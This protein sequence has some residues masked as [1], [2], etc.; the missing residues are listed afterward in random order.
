MVKVRSGT[1]YL[2]SNAAAKYVLILGMVKVRLGT[3]HLKSLTKDFHLTLTNYVILTK[4]K[5][6]YFLLFMAFSTF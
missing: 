5:K 1:F 2:K 6:N 3:F 4:K